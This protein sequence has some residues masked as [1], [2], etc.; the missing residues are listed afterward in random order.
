MLSFR[1]STHAKGASRC[2]RGGIHELGGFGSM[3]RSC[4]R[5][6]ADAAQLGGVERALPWTTRSSRV[7]RTSRPARPDGRRW[8]TMRSSGRL[9]T[10][11]SPLRPRSRRRPDA[12]ATGCR[13]LLETGLGLDLAGLDGLDEG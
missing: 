3:H 5:V 4:P 1:T 12:V 11:E 10:P 8:P 6:V 2:I 7:A 13:R 9:A